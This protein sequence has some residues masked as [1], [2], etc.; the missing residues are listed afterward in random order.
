MM[1]VGM[2]KNEAVSGQSARAC[3]LC[4]QPCS[5]EEAIRR[6]RGKQFPRVYFEEANG[7]VTLDGSGGV[8]GHLECFI[9]YKLM[10]PPQHHLNVWLDW[11]FQNKIVSW[12]DA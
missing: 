3:D 4:G 7:G 9:A 8:F 2:I 5:K 1:P 10:T 12:G 6:G 11:W